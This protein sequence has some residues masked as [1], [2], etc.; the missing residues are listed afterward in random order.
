M[1]GH[2]ILGHSLFHF[3]DV[4]KARAHYDEATARYK[5]EYRPLMARFGQDAR[6]SALIFR[7]MALWILG[8]PT[9]ALADGDRALSDAREIGQAATLM[10]A[11]FHRGA[12]PTFTVEMAGPAKSDVEGTCHFGGRKGRRVLE[13]AREYRELTFAPN[14]KR[15]GAVRMIGSGSRLITVNRSN[16]LMSWRSHI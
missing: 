7:A 3:G 13:D 16:T 6:V 4:A 5:S 1:V 11:L 12:L 8:H 10:Y 9:A 2:R 14:R 15:L